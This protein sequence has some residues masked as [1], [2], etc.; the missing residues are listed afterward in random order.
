MIGKSK[1]DLNTKNRPGDDR[2]V[3]PVIGVILMVAI[4]VLLAALAGVFVVGIGQ[5]NKTV[6]SAKFDYEYNQTAEEVTI[7]HV[8]GDEFND[9]N[10][11]SLEIV[12]YDN[13]GPDDLTMAGSG[14][15]V[16][17]GVNASAQETI[18]NA[19]RGDQIRIVWTHPDGSTTQV[20]SRYTV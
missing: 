17:S 14:F 13:T 10:S 5:D 18:R 6:P 8:G 19:K 9:G 12:L 2:A 15:D 4:T 16:D 3:S 11:E 7:T 1:I 20:V